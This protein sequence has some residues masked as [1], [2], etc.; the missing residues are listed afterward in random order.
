MY[1]DHKRMFNKIGP[2]G[3]SGLILERL[4]QNFNFAHFVVYVCCMFKVT[5]IFTTYICSIAGKF[6]PSVNITLM[7]E[8]YPSTGLVVTCGTQFLK[9]RLVSPSESFHQNDYWTIAVLSLGYKGTL[10]PPTNSPVCLS[11]CLLS[12]VIK[13]TLHPPTP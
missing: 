8:V 7:T 13:G 11:V 9:H 10:L 4:T 5:P 6:N 2:Q 12:C 3:P 1:Q